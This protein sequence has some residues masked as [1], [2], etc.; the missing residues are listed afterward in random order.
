MIHRC[1]LSVKYIKSM[2]QNVDDVLAVKS[3]STAP[4]SAKSNT[5]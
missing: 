1:V 3:L 2:D 4:K 5:G